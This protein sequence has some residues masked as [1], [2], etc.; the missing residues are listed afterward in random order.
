MDER[1]WHILRVA[2]NAEH[3][4]LALLQ[5]DEVNETYVPME[6]KRWFNRRTRSHRMRK[7]PLLPG[8]AFIRGIDPTLLRRP[9]SNLIY[10]FMRIG[11]RSFMKLSDSDIEGLR[12][13]ERDVEAGL[14][15]VQHSFR[16]DDTVTFRDGALQ[17]FQFIVESLIGLGRIKVRPVTE[18]MAFGSI[19]T[20]AASV[21]VWRQHAA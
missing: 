18:A 20:E 7:E 11:D 4:A 16:Q 8:M 13:V 10:G 21:K 5:L 15:Q 9:P 2:S 14:L 17:N 19:E 6:T 12:R 3:E 1:P